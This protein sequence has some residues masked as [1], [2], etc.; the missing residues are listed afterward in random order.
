MGCHSSNLFSVEGL[1][2]RYRF[3]PRCIRLHD[4]SWESAGLMQL[5]GI[6]V[7]FARDDNDFFVVFLR[8]GY[9]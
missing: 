8:S 1:V 2:V 4:C 3:Y 7:V 9:V 5:D 6:L